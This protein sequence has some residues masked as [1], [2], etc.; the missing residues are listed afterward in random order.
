MSGKFMKVKR[1]AIPTLT[2]VIIA[3]QLMG[4]AAAN[5]SELLDMINQGDQIEI[6]VAVPINEE[7]GTEES[8]T[9]EELASLTT[10]DTLRSEWDDILGIINTE[11][12]KNGVLYVDVTGVNNNNNTLQMALHNRAFV[13]L[14]ED[15]DSLLEL[16]EASMSQYADLDA[17]EEM[18]AYYMGINGYFN[19]LPDATPNY[20]NADSTLTRLEFMS[21]VT[22]AETP[23]QE[24]E[25][26]TVFATAVGNN[27]LNIYA[28]EVADSSYL[29]IESKSLNNMTANGT[30]TRGEVVYMLMN[31]YF[32]NELANVDLSTANLSDCIDGGNIAETQNFIEDGV[33]KEYWKSYELVYAIQN[34]DQ[35]VPTDMYK[36]LVLAEQMGI[37]NSETRWDEGIT[38]AEAVE[39]LVSALMQ[40]TSIEVFNYNQ[41]TITGYEAPEDTVVDENTNPND[42]GHEYAPTEEEE[43]VEEETSETTT[44]EETQTEEN[45]SSFQ[46]PD[47]ETRAWF[48]T[49]FGL[50]EDE[51]N[52]MTQQRYD[53]LLQ[54]WLSGGTGGSNNTGGNSGG[55]NN[56]GGSSSSGPENGDYSNGDTGGL[57]PAPLNPG[58]VG[59][60]M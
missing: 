23:V 15:E 49:E 45:Q 20:C 22:R 18:K 55:G 53:S 34:P 31:H 40:E 9:W 4:C 30:I 41:G 21:M 48:G 59:G 12:G 56:S 16:A 52:N 58:T 7:Q 44:E 25:A 29:D 6:E 8:I 17:E 28:Q 24:L 36:A 1:F 27:E 37:I 14:M 10:N 39:L 3:S 26:D 2:L 43:V 47:E 33:A 51:L 13:K 5:Q 46:W 42:I 50:S 35:G 57:A 11:T 60:N 19:L 38:K 32:P 54:N